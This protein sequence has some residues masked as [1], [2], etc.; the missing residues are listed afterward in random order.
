MDEQ[1]GRMTS[2]LLSLATVERL[3]AIVAE[4]RRLGYGGVPGALDSYGRIVGWAAD[5]AGEI[6]SAEQWAAAACDDVH[7]AANGG[8]LTLVEIGVEAMAAIDR[9]LAGAQGTVTYTPTP[10]TAIAWFLDVC[11]AAG[12]PAPGE[13]RD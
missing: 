12:C 13:G 8:A 5:V 2:A 10:S 3:D 11:R 4:V 6:G 9:A 1:T 7:A